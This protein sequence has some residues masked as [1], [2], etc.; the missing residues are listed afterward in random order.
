MQEKWSTSVGR[1]HEGA[2]RRY[3]WSV[4]GTPEE[5]HRATER[6]IRAE[7][8]ARTIERLDY[9]ANVAD[10]ENN[11]RLHS[12]ARGSI[13]YAESHHEVED[14]PKRRRGERHRVRGFERDVGGKAERVRPHLARNPRR[15]R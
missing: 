10:R 11:E 12:A 14:D 9:L 2:L 3:G 1:L 13:E 7:G 15:H 4:D 8:Y 6:S 5:R